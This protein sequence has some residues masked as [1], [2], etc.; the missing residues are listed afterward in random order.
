[1]G[2]FE[3]ICLTCPHE[4]G[5][6]GDDH[7]EC[8]MRQAKLAANRDRVRTFAERQRVKWGNLADLAARNRREWRKAVFRAPLW[9]EYRKNGI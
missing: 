2:R 5:C 8:P 1:M 6:I 4:A 7:P 9:R 3:K